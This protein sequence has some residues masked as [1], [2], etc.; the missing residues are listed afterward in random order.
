MV[1]SNIVGSIFCFW[2]NP[3]SDHPRTSNDVLGPIRRRVGAIPRYSVAWHIGYL[4]PLMLVTRL[5]NSLSF[6]SIVSRGGKINVQS[7]R[8]Y[9]NAVFA[10]TGITPAK[11]LATSDFESTAD[12]HVPRGVILKHSENASSSQS[13]RPRR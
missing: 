8:V 6:R 3:A 13:G 11:S 2:R 1:S 7:Q 4:Q 5:K 12:Y 10:W 9:L